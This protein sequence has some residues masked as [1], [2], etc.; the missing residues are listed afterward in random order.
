MDNKPLLVCVEGTDGSGKSTL[1]DGLIQY[2]TKQNLRIYYLHFPIYS[3]PLGKVI[4]SVLLKEQVMD[5]SAF[6]CL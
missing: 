4:K 2:Y 1:I 6:Q 5:I 3:D